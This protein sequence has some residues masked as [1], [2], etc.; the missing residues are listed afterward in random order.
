MSE[1]PLNI[2][3]RDIVPW[4]EQNIHGHIVWCPANLESTVTLYTK[5]HKKVVKITDDVFESLESCEQLN[6]VYFQKRVWQK[7][8]KALYDFM[9]D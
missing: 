7:E 5:D 8:L 3:E 1:C 6:F 4:H 2:P 9:G